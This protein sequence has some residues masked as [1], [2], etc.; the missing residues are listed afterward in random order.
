MLTL[1]ILV[2][3]LSAE[4]CAP[5]PVETALLEAALDSLEDSGG[6]TAD[7]GGEGAGGGGEGADAEAVVELVT[8]EPAPYAGLPPGALT[9]ED[10]LAAWGHLEQQGGGL[11]S[12][13]ALL[14]DGQAR[15]LPGEVIRGL[16]DGHDLDLAGFPLDKLVEI[17]SDGEIFEARFSFP[18]MHEVTLPDSG[19]WVY[20]R[21]RAR[22]QE[23]EGQRVR[24]S[25]AV[26]F[27]ISEAGITGVREG[28]IQAYGGWLAGWVNL[29]VSTKRAPGQVAQFGGDP[30]LQVGE[31]GQPL[32]IDGRYQYQTYDDWLVVTGPFGFRME[33][34]IPD[35]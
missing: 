15:T 12:F 14:A 30:V 18:G 27:T 23:E 33:S 34:G 13:F 29:G 20:R 35:L 6:A 1:W 31:D 19:A 8:D 22:Y 25:S 28:D 2:A 7:L 10:L 9:S 4:D 24:F 17:Y 5:T 21:G 3:P 16:T 26:R 11:Q 32:V